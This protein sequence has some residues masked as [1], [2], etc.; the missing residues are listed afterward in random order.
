MLSVDTTFLE[1]PLWSTKRNVVFLGDV[2]QRL[3]S[4]ASCVEAGVDVVDQKDDWTV[5]ARSSNDETI[6]DGTTSWSS[7]GRFSPAIVA[8]VDKQ[9]V[10]GIGYNISL[11]KNNINFI[12][13]LVYTPV[14]KEGLQITSKILLYAV[15]VQE[16]ERE[17]LKVERQGVMYIGLYEFASLV[18]NG[19]SKILETGMRSD[20]RFQVT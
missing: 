12:L 20:R 16:R 1:A 11:E 19:R 10:R 9:D 18:W 6:P 13:L 17:L 15:V 2:R 8:M 5:A 7:N 4:V 3:E 14:F